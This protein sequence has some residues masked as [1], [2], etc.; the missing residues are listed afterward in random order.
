MRRRSE[1][2]EE[3]LHAL[4]RLADL[5]A[6]HGTI[7]E[8]NSPTYH[9]ITLLL[10][11]VISILGEP[12]TSSL[13]SRLEKHLWTEVAWR[14][15]PRLRQLCGPWGRAY[16][17]S[18]VGGSGLMLMLA[19]IMWGAFYDESVAFRYQ[20]GHDLTFAPVLALLAQGHPVDVM[21]VALEKDFPLTVKASAEQVS[22]RFGDDEHT[23]WVPGGIAELTTWMDRNLAVGTASRSHIHAIQNGSFI[24]QWSRTGKAVKELKDLGQA[25]VRL[26]QNGRR[27][28]RGVHQLYRNHY[29]GDPLE[30]TSKLWAD[31]GHPYALQ[32][33]P[34]SL[35]AYVP[36]GWER[37]WVRKLEVMAVIPRLDTVDSVTVN[38]S[39]VDAYRGPAGG[40]V[41]VR[42]GNV[43]LGL[44]FA[45]CATDLFD[46]YLF[47]ER[48]EDHLLVGICTAE[49]P[50]ERELP[51]ST[52]RRYGASIGCELRYTPNPSD[53][54]IFVRDLAESR[55][56]DVWPEGVFGF[57]R[58]VCFQIGSTCLRG[59]LDP[60]SGSWL[61]RETPDPPGRVVQIKFRW[62]PAWRSSLS[63]RGCDAEN[64][65]RGGRC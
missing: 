37:W 35:V 22:V 8:F 15:H 19:D 2:V 41:L 4:E 52:Y 60:V 31:D 25:F 48:H 65:G 9:P 47:V 49:F 12:R 16:H 17:D 34:T 44:R 42:S 59:R 40:W 57:A 63:S 32:S 39:E 56:S 38:G 58:E 24:A 30:T 64:H 21:R 50:D 14:W 13:A 54:D 33:G 11:R 61:S 46:P 10:L 55:I 6:A 7:P 51:E 45:A 20:H 26:S 36:K 23:S 43:S 29:C 27:P 3:G 18:L 62:K 1:A 53:I 5:V 28:G